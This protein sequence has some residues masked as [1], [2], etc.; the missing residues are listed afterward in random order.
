MSLELAVFVGVSLVLALIFAWGT[1]LRPGAGEQ[2][3][4]HRLGRD[5][6]GP[7]RPGDAAPP[8]LFAVGLRTPFRADGSDALGARGV[9]DGLIVEGLREVPA[10]GDDRYS[11]A[12]ALGQVLPRGPSIDSRP[13]RARADA[14]VLGDPDFDER[15]ALHGSR[16]AAVLH[17]DA[18]ARR[19]LRDA[20]RAGWR[21]EGDRITC[22]G[23]P[24][25]SVARYL[26]PG[27]SAA[28]ALAVDEVDAPRRLARTA[29]ED[30]AARMRRRAL[31]L[32][33]RDHAGA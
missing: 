19:R 2:R 14:L 29:V 27:T 31:H 16:D 11:L 32:L 5:E 6:V 24:E 25:E 22:L 4:R 13:E 33:L 10:S 15:F 7:P 28:R 8:P 18:D 23:L 9:I 26:P 3:A 30:P 20:E 21:L 12:I 1:A 17:V